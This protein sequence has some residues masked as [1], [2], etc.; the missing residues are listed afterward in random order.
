MNEIKLDLKDKKILAEIEMNARISHSVLAKKVGLSKQVVKY[1]I[2]KLEENKIIE[3]YNALVDLNKLGYTIYL[4]YLKLF[5]ISSEKEKSW[6]K[7]MTKNENVMAIGK[8]AGHWDMSILLKCQSNQELDETF[9]KIINGKADKI[10]EKLITS[11]IESTYFNLK[12]LHKILSV[13]R[14]TSS[15]QENIKIDDEDSELLKFLSD[16]CTMNLVD[17]ATK[18]RMSA[19]GV[20]NRI[21]NL[22]KK[23]IIMGYKTKINYEKLG[24][25]HFRVFIHVNKFSNELYKKMKAFLNSKGN[26]ESVS[27]YMGYADLD[28]RCYSQSLIELY[29][30][31][32]EIKDQFVQDIIEIDS[33]PIFN[34]EK[35]TYF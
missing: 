6:V 26:I 21:K 15:K 3:G 9:K 28:F 11:E 25:L 29:N 33:M 16:N 12:L 35:I 18:L 32:S 27:R 22:E 4:I 5:K 34:W 19:N 1:R 14:N 23:G 20:K 8:N 30:L 31:I 17:L 7:E 24:F 13:T 10:K 2:E